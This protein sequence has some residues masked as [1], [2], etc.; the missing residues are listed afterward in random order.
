MIIT[1]SDILLV[2]SSASSAQLD[3][4]ESTRVWTGRQRPNFD[5][6]RT[7]FDFNDSGSTVQLSDAGRTALAK[8]QTS[9]SF[10]SVKHGDAA[11]EAPAVEQANAAVE[12]DPKLRLIISL[13]ERLSGRKINLFH[14]S[15]LASS[16]SISKVPSITSDDASD[17]AS[18]SANVPSSARSRNA[19]RGLEY[20][21][22]SSYTETEQ[23]SFQAT[24]L[25][26]M[27]IMRKLNLSSA[28]NCNAVITRRVVSACRLVAVEKLIHLLLIF[29]QIRHNSLRRNFRLT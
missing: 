17:R 7:S 14:V 9:F 2:S 13:I 4:H 16:E 28:F 5:N 6:S 19:G 11:G 25:I 15:D 27:R 21:R 10:S 20:Q 29:L 23:T 1:S 3:V 8:D 24:G 22:Q 12:N 26:H 18:G